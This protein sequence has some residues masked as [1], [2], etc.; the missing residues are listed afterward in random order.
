MCCVPKQ[1]PR[2]EQTLAKDPVSEL[3]EAT[4]P[5]MATVVGTKNG[6]WWC[7]L[8]NLVLCADCHTNYCRDTPGTRTGRRRINV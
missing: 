7:R 1:P 4:R 8:C 3:V 2:A 5:E 6:A